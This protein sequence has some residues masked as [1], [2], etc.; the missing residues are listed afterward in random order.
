MECYNCQESKTCPHDSAKMLGH[1][2]NGLQY[3]LDTSNWES[4]IYVIRAVIGDE[5]Y[6]QKITVN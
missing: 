5:V 6:S 4:G 2:V 1:K 3:T